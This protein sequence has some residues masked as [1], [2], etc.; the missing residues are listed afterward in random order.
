M[1]TL[2]L[3]LVAC[4]A[5]ACSFVSERLGAQDM[6]ATL[7]APEP[8]V[9]P[10]VSQTLPSVVTI[11]QPLRMLVIGDSLAEGFG[12]LLRQQVGARDLPLTVVNA[13]R[14]SSGLARRDFYDWPTQFSGMVAGNT[15]DI[16]VAHFGANDMQAIIQPSSRT[17]LGS[18]EWDAVYTQQIASILTTAADAG[19][20]VYLLGPATDVHTNL[21]N[22]LA[23]VN[24]LFEAAAADYGAI[25]FPLRPF[26][27]G[28]SG[29][30]AQNV[31]VNGQSV[32]L[33]SGDGSHF[34]NRGY[35]LVSDR[36]LD[37]LLIR[38]P[39]LEPSAVASEVAS[40]DTLSVLALQ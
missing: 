26:T 37:D 16:V 20:V 38:F 8:V 9:F 4:L 21:N 25:Y 27:S 33:R 19:A 6:G 35:R 23:R 5:T 24:P 12:A 11:E 13:G 40:V 32:R 7:T 29:E 39:Q 2:S 17:A 36:I 30:F 22:H 18:S 28:P 15:P 31:V 3:A 34:T 10:Q 14:N 1:R